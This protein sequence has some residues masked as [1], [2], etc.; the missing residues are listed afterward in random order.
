M[1][2]KTWVYNKQYQ[3]EI[4]VVDEIINQGHNKCT[5]N[6]QQHL[7]TDLLIKELDE[8]WCCE[9]C[10]STDVECKIWV[11]MNTNE[12]TNACGDEEIDNWCNN[13]GDHV[14]ITALDTYLNN[15]DEEE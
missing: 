1:K 7:I 3:K 2:N 14:Y 5:I 9:L 10:G 11:N 6:S 4:G 13:C 12:T 15:R 8:V